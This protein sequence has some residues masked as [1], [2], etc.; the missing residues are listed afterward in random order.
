MCTPGNDLLGCRADAGVL[1][2][3]ADGVAAEL[4]AQGGQHAPGERV[5]VARVE[6]AEQGEGDDRARLRPAWRMNHTGVMS[7]GW[8]RQIASMRCAPV[9]APAVTVT[10]I[11]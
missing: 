4:V 11:R 9:I 8:R 5:L 2:A 3:N 1:A 7:A 6:A 10:I